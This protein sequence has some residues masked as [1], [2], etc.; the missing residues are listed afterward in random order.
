LQ[1]LHLGYCPL[2]ESLTV[3]FCSLNEIGSMKGCMSLQEVD[4][5]FNHISQLKILVDSL[6]HYNLTTFKFN[7]NLFSAISHDEAFYAQQN[8]T[9]T[10]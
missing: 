8:Q 3:S 10:L 1:S 5:S 7:D 9:S 4:V 2:L 6:P